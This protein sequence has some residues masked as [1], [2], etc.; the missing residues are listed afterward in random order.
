MKAIPEAVFCVFGKKQGVLFEM[1]R[2]DLHKASDSEKR[3]YLKVQEKCLEPKQEFRR[4]F[5]CYHLKKPCCFQVDKVSNH[6]DRELNP[7]CSEIQKSDLQ[8][9][10]LHQ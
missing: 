2:K 4:L 10:L 3:D 9:A 5:Q 1:A 6:L 8:R 7:F